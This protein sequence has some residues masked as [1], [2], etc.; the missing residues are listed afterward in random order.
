MEVRT[1]FPYLHQLGIPINQ[2]S[3]ST[4]LKEIVGLQR[5]LPNN[6]IMQYTTFTNHVCNVVSIPVAKNEESFMR[7]NRGQTKWFGHL[8]SFVIGSKNDL[9]NESEVAGWMI[10]RL[11]TLHSDCFIKV[12]EEL[13]Y[14]ISSKNMDVDTTRGLINN[15]LFFATCVVPL[16]EDVLSPANLCVINTKVK[17]YIHLLIQFVILKSFLMKTLLIGPNQFVNVLTFLLYIGWAKN[18]V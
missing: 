3:I 14:S 7:I 6:N 18:K 17:M 4:L 16:G 5:S 9:I 2:F 12:C 10:K 1:K 15:G 13:G 8:P 11:A